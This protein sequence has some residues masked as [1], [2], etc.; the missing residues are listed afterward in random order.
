M[1]LTLVFRYGFRDSFSHLK[2]LALFSLLLKD[3]WWAPQG[4]SDQATRI[5][6]E[7]TLTNG[8][9]VQLLT[10][11]FYQ[12]I[13]NDLDDWKPTQLT[14][15][16]APIKCEK[17]FNVCNKFNVWWCR[18]IQQCLLMKVQDIRTNGSMILSYCC[19]DS[20]SSFIKGFF[21]NTFFF[22]WPLGIL[23]V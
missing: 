15:S 19:F 21:R 4:A 2:G 16:G 7:T 6:G 1:N 9:Q 18:K 5:S 17:H 12:T 22:K 10:N 20:Y 3:R 8:K 14:S 11:K 23:N 13:C